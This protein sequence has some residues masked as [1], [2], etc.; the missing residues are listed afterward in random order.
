M[1]D[2]VERREPTDRL[3]E[4]SLTHRSSRHLGQFSSSTCQRNSGC[5]DA[6]VHLTLLGIQCKIWLKICSAKEK[7][8]LPASSKLLL[9]QTYTRM[10][11]ASSFRI[12]W[13]IQHLFMRQIDVITRCISLNYH[14][15]RVITRGYLTPYR[16]PRLAD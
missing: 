9:R 5:D 3:S 11:M 13:R 1:S 6:S 16:L 15:R 14:L 12:K 10:M 2:R 7:L 8:Y 4:L